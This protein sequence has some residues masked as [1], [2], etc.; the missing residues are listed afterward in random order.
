MGKNSVITVR[1]PKDLKEK[2]GQLAK[3]QGISMNQ[4]AMY[5]LTKETGEIESKDYFRKF[6]KNK[7]KE[8]IYKGFDQTMAI[9]KDRETPDWDKV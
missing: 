8:E 1:L 5:A 2:I 3:E 4:F 7:E 9:I 6:L